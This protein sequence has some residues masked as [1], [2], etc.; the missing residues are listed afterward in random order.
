MKDSFKDLIQSKIK[1]I[2]SKENNMKYIKLKTD[3]W[4][5][6]QAGMRAIGHDFT[7]QRLKEQWSRMKIHARTSVSNFKRAQRETGGGECAEEPSEFDLEI[8]DM[9]PHN[10]EEDHALYDSDIVVMFK[11]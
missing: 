6:I 7:I 9:N 2:D 1:I 11:V 10:F 4:T 3:A 5:S 8:V